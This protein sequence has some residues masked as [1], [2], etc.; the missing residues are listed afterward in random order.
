MSRVTRIIGESV[1]HL[2]LAVVGL[3]VLLILF[4]VITKGQPKGLIVRTGSMEPT[5]PVGSFIIVVPDNEYRLGDIVTFRQGENLVTHRIIGNENVQFQ[6]K[7][8][9][10]SVSDT[11]LLDPSMIVGK[12]WY[13]IPGLGRLLSETKTPI[14][15]SLLIILPALVIILREISAI[16]KELERT[17]EAKKRRLGQV[18]QW[19]HYGFPGSSTQLIGKRILPILIICF[20]YF[21]T[22]NVSSYAYVTD[23]AFDNNN[24]FNA[25]QNFHILISEVY[26]DV[27]TPASSC[28]TNPQNEWVELYNPTASSII[29]TGW[30]LTDNNSSSTL[31]SGTTIGPGD[32]LVVTRELAT[33]T[34]WPAV[35]AS[36]Q[37]ILGSNIGNGLSDSNDRVILKNNLGT[38]ID[39]LS[40]GS[41]LTIFNPS[42]PDVAIGHSI[43]RSPV[44]L[45]TNTASD[46]V[47]RVTPTPGS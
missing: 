33:F 17:E 47:D 21:L 38:V 22:T 6:T 16:G 8:D 41:D 39:A 46:F 31:P 14:G 26:Y 35:I 3:V 28:G 5:I 27:C 36:Q 2:S 24:T 43:E 13:S 19:R 9:A 11:K 25:S 10:N 40:Y 37:V 12:L 1:R 32:Y 20:L 45:D 23:L 29:L 42:V 15:F 44:T 18:S 30:S 4:V 7:G 34:F